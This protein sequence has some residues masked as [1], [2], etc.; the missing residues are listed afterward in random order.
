MLSMEIT[1]LIERCREG[2]GEALGLLY[3]AYAERMRGVCRRYV[4]NREAVDDVLHDAFV[5]IFTSF[6]RL[7]DA[8]KVEAWMAVTRN[9]ALKYCEQERTRATAVG[10][11][12]EGLADAADEAD[13]EGSVRGVP[14]EEVMRLIEQLPEGYRR[15]FRLSV[16]EG[17]S[18]KEIAR[19]LGIEPHSSSSQLARA[20]KMLRKMMRRYWLLVLLLL[21]PVAMRWGWMQ[22]MGTETTPNIAEKKETV[23]TQGGRE[24]R[25]SDERQQSPNDG[26]RPSLS[27]MVRPKAIA[28]QE[29]DVADGTDTL[30]LQLAKA[31]DGDTL[32][33]QL[34]KA[35]DGNTLPNN[36]AGDGVR[37]IPRRNLP[38]LPLPILGKQQKGAR[39]WT[40]QLA[41]AGAYDEQRLRNQ[42]YSIRTAPTDAT[43][44]P[45]VPT[46]IDNWNDYLV[47]LANHPGEG[48][49]QSR[50]AIL[51]IALNNACRPDGGKMLRT[52]RHAMPVTWSLALKYRINSR[53]GME[54]GLNYSRLTSRFEMGAEGDFIRERQTIHYVGIPVKGIYTLHHSRRWNLY[55]SAGM[56]V[57][58]PVRSLLRSDYYVQGTLKATDKAALPHAPWQFSA[59][60]GL[61]VQYSLTPRIG[62]FAE[63][64]VQYFLPT[65]GDVSTY[66]TAHPTSVTLPVGIRFTW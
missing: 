6:H 53:W 38:D 9:V 60:T 10:E 63:P 22:R 27:D 7:R 15:V 16:F 11:P 12:V 26:R 13:D 35:D 17:L 66:R 29:A 42:P 24:K 62:L 1:R 33:L 64:G 28:R 61:G 58:M 57:E 59:H 20:K 14:V 3:A 55:G 36:H 48:S 50:E 25:S 45:T 39:R 31:D 44:A 43:E 21:L 4:G 19:Q 18:H 37:E 5:I 32:S 40:L 34:A 2:D 52:S 47:Y 54:T 65:G 8:Q 23:A 56:S 30:S 46:S 49:P 51:Q 41:Y